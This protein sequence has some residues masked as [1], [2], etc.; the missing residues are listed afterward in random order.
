MS[1]VQKSTKVAPV[2]KRENGGVESLLDYRA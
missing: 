1:S 2:R